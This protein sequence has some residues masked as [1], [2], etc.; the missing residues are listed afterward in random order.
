MVEKET[1]I[2]DRLRKERESLGH[3]LKDVARKMG[4]ENHQVLGNIESGKRPLKASE[5]VQLSRLY[6]RNLDYFLTEQ[7][8]EAPRILWRERAQTEETLLAERK[9][10]EICD[11]YRRLLKLTG[12]ATGTNALLPFLTVPSKQA[13][14][15][16]RFD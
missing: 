5:L 1:L 13:L 7:T 8:V 4:F 14:I 16:G 9:F 12:E 3:K 6:G 15:H 11:G 2:G 10:I